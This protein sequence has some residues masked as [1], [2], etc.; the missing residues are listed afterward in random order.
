MDDGESEL[1][2]D[3]LRSARR[4]F[5]PSRGDE[6]RVRAAIAKLIA[7]APPARENGHDGAT[8]EAAASAV[9]R[10]LPRVL[11]GVALAGGGGVGYLAGYR[12]GVADGQARS[13][14]NPVRV[15]AAPASRAEQP[16]SGGSGPERLP[17]APEPVVPRAVAAPRS[18]L[19][20]NEPD[21]G[22]DLDA[23]VRLLKRVERAL[24]DQNP[25]YALGLL[26]ELERTVPGG[27]L[28]E[29]RH[30]AKVMA[31]CQLTGGSRALIEEF[32]KA[33]PG[34]AY[35]ARVAETCGGTGEQRI[36]GDPETH[37]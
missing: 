14:A 36:S 27:Q 13:V 10:W 6:E 25:R 9:G 3:V 12:V 33:H 22:L 37:P 18:P 4:G 19:V 11:L 35:S 17:V 1:E 30:A 8:S 23:E 26:G 16:S 29:E 21:G 5:S 24:R 7:V 15:T 2:R 34:S 20:V 31:R 32:S 28:V